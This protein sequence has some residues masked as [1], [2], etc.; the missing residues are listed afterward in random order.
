MPL[1]F[2]SNILTYI[3]SEED[4]LPKTFAKKIANML[5]F[6]NIL[7]HDY[8]RVDE[9]I[10][11]DILKNHLDDFSQFMNYVNKWI[12]TRYQ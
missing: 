10:M 6:R 4:I 3:Q 8:M 2:V 7:V 5:S 1:F 12:N 11:V 9:K